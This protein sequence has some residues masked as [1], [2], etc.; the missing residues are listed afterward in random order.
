M[1]AEGWVPFSEEM[2]M[3]EPL[4][5]D[6]PPGVLERQEDPRQAEVDDAPPRLQRMV[7]HGGER[8]RPGIGN[9]HV[10]AA[11]RRDREVGEGNHVGFLG[12][13]G[14]QHRDRAAQLFGDRGECSFVDV[15][16]HERGA[17]GG[18]STGDRPADWPAPVIQPATLPSSV[19]MG[20]S[21]S[22]PAIGT[23]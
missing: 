10:E 20:V 16:E 2:A 1:P 8:P 14:P 19:P 9:R 15:A 11:V 12:H 3:I 13:V 5:V 17:F 7:D 6:H 23:A 21:S 22:A 4:V 18:V